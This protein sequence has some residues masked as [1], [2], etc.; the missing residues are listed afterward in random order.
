[1][2]FSYDSTLS[3]NVDIV[4]FLIG[5]TAEPALFTDE[6]LSAL[7]GLQTA[8]GAALPYF[9]AAEAL[10]TLSGRYA[11]AGKGTIQ[12]TVSKLTKIWGVNEDANDALQSRISWLRQRGA[13]LLSQ[14]PF[15][16]R[17]AGGSRT[18]NFPLIR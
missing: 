16:F 14:R 8:T 4:R 13:F 10:S 17:I 6:E 18:R 9:A 12:K 1:M 3:S 7:L 2:S 11:N 15:S 5:D